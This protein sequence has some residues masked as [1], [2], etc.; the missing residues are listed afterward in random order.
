[1]NQVMS[2]YFQKNQDKIEYDDKRVN[3]LDRNL[4]RKFNS[5]SNRGSSHVHTYRVP[6]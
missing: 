6:G 1:M 5:L 3:L 2:E 4:T